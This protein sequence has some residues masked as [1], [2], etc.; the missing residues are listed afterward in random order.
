[1]TTHLIKFKILSTLVMLLTLEQFYKCTHIYSFAFFCWKRESGFETSLA[2]P[3][4]M[5]E[6]YGSHCVCVCVYVCYY[7]SGYIYVQSE[8]TYSFF[9]LLKIYI[10]LKTRCSEEKMSLA[11]HDDRQL[12]SFSI[13]NTPMVF[14]TIKMV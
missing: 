1:M 2:K 12:G 5:H 11:F 9:R 14:D 10:L 3:W 6:G 4:R 13:K 7:A 8:A